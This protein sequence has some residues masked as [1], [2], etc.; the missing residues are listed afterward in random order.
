MLA[1]WG[2]AERFAPPSGIL[3]STIPQLEA[4]QKSLLKGSIG[5]AVQDGES[6][7]EPP[8]FD[9]R[10]PPT[11]TSP[12]GLQN[13]SNSS[14]AQ[15]GKGNSSQKKPL[16]KVAVPNSSDQPRSALF[17]TGT[18]EP[19]GSFSAKL[20][21]TITALPG[22]SGLNTGQPSASPS[23]NSP[24]D[25]NNDSAAVTGASGGEATGAAPATP[26]STLSVTVDPG[27][28]FPETLKIPIGTKLLGGG[29]TPVEPGGAFNEKK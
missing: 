6:N 16:D 8:K 17:S 7:A 28:T 29:I 10:Q 9:E 20:D 1:I 3:A 13:S 19:G 26:R 14:T 24:A 22:G 15:D 27:G 11:Q 23:K 2:A 18:P 12:P 21:L 4:T 5:T 25:F